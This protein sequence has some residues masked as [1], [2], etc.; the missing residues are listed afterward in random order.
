VKDEHN[1]DVLERISREE[2]AHY[3]YLKEHTA[4]E[5]KPN[6]LRVWVFVIIAKVLG[7]TFS[8]KLMEKREDAAR[9][10]Y[11]DLGDVIRRAGELAVGANQD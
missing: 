6:T 3:N 9:G 11:S 4:Q 1:R 10:S 2:L 5:V 7:I 8:L